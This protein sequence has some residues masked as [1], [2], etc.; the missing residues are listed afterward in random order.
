MLYSSG[1]PCDLLLESRIGTRQAGFPWPEHDPSVRDLRRRRLLRWSTISF[2]TEHFTDTHHSNLATF[3]S[4][5]QHL[6]TVARNPPSSGLSSQNLLSRVRNATPKELAF[7]GVT[8]AEIVGFFTV[9]E[10]VGRLHIVGYRG[11]PVHHGDH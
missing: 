4:Y 7:V 2:Q 10:I 3:Q 9:G 11:E 6:L 1:T 5:Y 8:A